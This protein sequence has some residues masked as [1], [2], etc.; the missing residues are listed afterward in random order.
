MCIAHMQKR[1]LFHG[2]HP[3]WALLHLWRKRPEPGTSDS[4]QASRKDAHAKSVKG[5]HLAEFDV[6][7]G[8]AVPCVLMDDK[9]YQTVLEVSTVQFFGFKN[10]NY[11]VVKDMCAPFI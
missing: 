11:K 2:C 1:T 5:W 3:L 4:R 9:V 8:Y 6:A 10:S 7:E